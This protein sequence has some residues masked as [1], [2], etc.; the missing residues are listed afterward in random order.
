MRKNLLKKICT[1]IFAAVLLASCGSS[2]KVSRINVGE[3]VDL[4]GK[5]NDTDSRLV[6]KDLIDQ[7]LD[8]RWL[9]KY[10]RE[11][12]KQPVVIVGKVKNKTSE[13]IKTA[14]F[15][16]D[17]ERNLINSGEVEFVASS[18]D[19]NELRQERQEQQGHASMETTKQ[20]GN[21]TGADFMLLGQ[22][23]S[24]TDAIDGEKVVY[25]QIDMELVNIETNKKAWAGF[26]KIKKYIGQ[27]KYGM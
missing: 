7:V 3:A 14:T 13:H 10:N 11:N 19:R 16:K 25:Y 26:K 27:D 23:N 1:L 2:R 4:S 17:L 12:G 8:A 21:E 6:S 20:M 9:T 5:W 22:I 15:V 18:K 24:I